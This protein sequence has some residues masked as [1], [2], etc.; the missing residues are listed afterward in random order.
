MNIACTAAAN[1]TVTN[2]TFLRNCGGTANA[3][4]RI[5]TMSSA[6][7]ADVSVGS[8]RLLGSTN[9]QGMGIE[10]VSG[11]NAI[12]VNCTA[13]RTGTASVL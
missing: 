10:I 3:A 5:S 1:I 13:S 2:L 11:R 6:S 9:H 8:C 7:G 12:V 4:L